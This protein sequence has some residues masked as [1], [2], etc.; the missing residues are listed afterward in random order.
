MTIKGIENMS[1]SDLNLEWQRGGRLV[2][3]QYRVSILIMTFK[4]PSAIY[5]ILFGLLLGAA[6]LV[7]A[8]HCGPTQPLPEFPRHSCKTHTQ[9]WQPGEKID[10]HPGGAKGR[11]PG[12]NPPSGT[13]YQDE[14][15]T[16][17]PSPENQDDSDCMPQVDPQVLERL[18]NEKNEVLRMLAGGGYAT[19]LTLT[20]MGKLIAARLSHLTEPNEGIAVRTWRQA[21]SALDNAPAAV[22][23]AAQAT[24]AYLANDN[25]ANHRYLYGQV[26]RGVQLAEQDLKQKLRNPHITI[27]KIADS[28]LVGKLTGAAGSMCK[29]WGADKLAQFKNK[30]AEARKA[31]QTFGSVQDNTNQFAQTAQNLTRPTGNGQIQ[32]RPR[33]SGPPDVG[34]P[35]LAPIP[36]FPNMRI[37]PTCYENQCWPNVQAVD[38]Y[39]KTGQWLEPR[40]RGYPWAEELSDLSTPNS[41]IRR[42]LQ[43]KHGGANA[44]DPGHGPGGLQIMAA[45]DAV[46]SSKAQIES[47]LRALGPG[48]QGYVFVEWQ[49]QVGNELVKASHVVNVRTLRD[50]TVQFFDRATLTDPRLRGAVDPNMWA[51]ATGVW[52]HRSW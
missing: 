14:I 26:Q 50:R 42:D 20:A 4:R 49:Q 29:R 22:V 21:Q 7:E 41:L 44:L 52:F 8:H 5:F 10:Q 11:G 36:E 51:S 32:P 46:T 27:A 45:G 12:N 25:A 30:I 28:L 37:P 38:E 3:F 13:P 39:W 47:A 6:N 17:G 19:D 35:P 34:P 23:N 15:T 33:P 43:R 18:K 31:K 40:P 9:T 16:A 48:K 1:T 24:A 2:V